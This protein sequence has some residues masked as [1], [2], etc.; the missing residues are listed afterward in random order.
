[1][2]K[3]EGTGNTGL[4]VFIAFVLIVIFFLL[5]ILK[6]NAWGKDTRSGQI[7]TLIRETV[8]DGIKLCDLLK[9]ESVIIMNVLSFMA[10]S[11]HNPVV[12]AETDRFMMLAKEAKDLIIESKKLLQSI[13][14]EKDGKALIQKLSRSRINIEKAS[15]IHKEVFIFFQMI[16]YPLME[17]E[18]KAIKVATLQRVA[19]FFYSGRMIERI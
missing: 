11:N 6:E 1:M 14:P 19:K 13:D 5:F 2:K 9:E 7:L 17:E 8:E 3:T 18:Q 10:A 16:F 4:I 12:C 15:K